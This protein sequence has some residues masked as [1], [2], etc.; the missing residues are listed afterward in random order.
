MNW[1]R[2]KNTSNNPVES[3]YITDTLYFNNDKTHRIVVK[4][5]IYGSYIYYYVNNEPHIKRYLEG[6]YMDEAKEIIVDLVKQKATYHVNFY[7]NVLNCLKNK[8]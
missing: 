8:E 2:Q 6:K 7:Q 3:Q 4:Q 5:L 1:I